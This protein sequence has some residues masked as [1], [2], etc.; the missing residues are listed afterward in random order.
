MTNK[1]S[2]YQRLGR[3]QGNLMGMNI[4]SVKLEDLLPLIFNECL[5]ENLMFYFN[6]IENACV[7]NLRD[8]RD[9]NLQLNIRLYYPNE[10]KVS[11]IELKEQILLNAFLLTRKGTI[12]KSSGDASSAD[13][14]ETPKKEENLSKPI[15]ESNI[16]PPRAIRAAMDTITARGD[17]VTKTALE[18]EL[19]LNKMS[20][21]NRRQ[22][23]A[24]LRD[25]EA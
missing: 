22:C 10:A 17:E 12:L 20:T 15:Q 4:P 7:L 19:Q 24:Y 25:M 5:K 2:I 21:D 11:C 23:I 1:V 9:E 14:E 18:K 16:V 8:I 13:I 6:F 3:V